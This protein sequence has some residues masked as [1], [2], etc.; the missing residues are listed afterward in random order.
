MMV[1]IVE[2]GISVFIYFSCSF[3][4]F[5][6]VQCLLAAKAGATYVSPF[7][8]RLDDIGHDGMEVIR[9]ARTIFDNYG[10]ETQIL[11]AS[12]RHPR[13]VVEAA[14]VGSDVATIPTTVQKERS[15]RARSNHPQTRRLYST[16]RHS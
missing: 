12:I 3:E 14:L 16:Q 8:G 5:N 1:W 2:Y 9:E 4:R 11:T 6:S 15:R 10:L 7:I 13:H